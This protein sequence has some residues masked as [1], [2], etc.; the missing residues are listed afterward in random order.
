[1]PAKPSW[2]LRIPAILELLSRVP[3]PVVDRA[4]CE[5]LFGVRRRRAIDLLRHFGGYRAGNTVLID[6]IALIRTLRELQ[7]D[8][9]VQR[10][11][12]RK[13]RIA[14]EIEKCRRQTSASR[15]TITR[16]PIT[17]CSATWLP[18]PGIAIL[19]GS[20]VV[21]FDSPNELLT[22]LYALAESIGAN[23]DAFS[24]ALV[25]QRRVHR[26]PED[27]AGG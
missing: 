9:D 25:A 15:V 2:L 26:D 16:L 22:R 14:E 7:A 10:E 3:V 27:L 18:P 5:R 19:P 8:P 24:T 1:M 12:A 4:T 23:Y 13:Q 21:Q 17:R 6:R 11:S 20:L